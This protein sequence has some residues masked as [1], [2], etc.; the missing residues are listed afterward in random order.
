MRPARRSQC[1]NNLKQ[2]GLAL[3]NFT[4]TK[5]RYPLGLSDGTDGFQNDGYGWAV[6]L[7]PN[8]E[9]Q[10]LYDRIKPK[11]APGIFQ[12]T[13]NLNKKIIPGGDTILP[14]FRCPTSE[15]GPLSIGLHPQLVHGEGYATSDY[16]ACTGEGDNGI[17]FRR[18]D[19]LA[20]IQGKAKMN[21]T[22]SRPADVT[23]GLS[24]T[25]ALGESAYYDVTELP[26]AT[27]IYRWPIW[28]GAY[29]KNGGENTYG[30]D[31]VVLFKTDANAVINCLISPKAVA[32]F[33]TAMDDDCAFSWHEGGAYF[34]FADGSVHFLLETIDIDDYRHLGSKNDGEII[35]GF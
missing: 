3:I 35:R 8:L 28:L 2:I 1:Q 16:K 17:F 26:S 21:Y 32:Y 4:E 11:S 20:A 30:V 22:R 25:I 19:G 10:A 27:Y 7:L 33:K 13:Y 9:E 29:G 24:K 5:K 15:L 34:A 14:V 6:W 12:W 23:D 18:A 31:E